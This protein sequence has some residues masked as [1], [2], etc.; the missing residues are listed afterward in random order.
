MM[1]LHAGIL[2]PVC[3]KGRASDLCYTLRSSPS[4]G[5]QT[6]FF[7]TPIELQIKLS[8]LAGQARIQVTFRNGELVTRAGSFSD[9]LTG[10]CNDA[11]P[12]HHVATFF[13][14]RLGN[15]HD[16]GTVLVSARLHAKT[17]LKQALGWTLRLAWIEQRRVV[18][19]RDQLHA[20]ERKYAVGF[21]PA[22]VIAD[23]HAEFTAKGL[24]HG[25]AEITHLK[26]HFLE[27]LK[28]M[29]RMNLTVPRQMHLA[30]L[31]DDLPLLA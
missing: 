3:G 1:F 23:G 6:V 14:P 7:R 5:E 28:W 27:I 8:V 12:G 15:S 26:I 2:P 22:S 19:E 13:Q 9:N 11:G 17:V 10:G 21:R 24:E 20:L 31:A 4:L 16:P 30:V 25:K 18:A 29:L